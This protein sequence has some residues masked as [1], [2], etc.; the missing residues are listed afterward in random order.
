MFLTSLKQR[1]GCWHRP[2]E[3]SVIGRNS[4][5][6]FGTRT[7]HLSCA[8]LGKAHI[9]DGL[10]NNADEKEVMGRLVEMGGGIDANGPTLSELQALLAAGRI[11]SRE[12]ADVLRAR[13]NRYATDSESPY[14][15][16]AL[17]ALSVVDP[18]VKI[19]YEKEEKKRIGSLAQIES[20][21]IRGCCAGHDS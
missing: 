2:S 10:N 20:G 21:K 3:C 13:V 6:R 4:G 15:I 18:E 12:H 17:K 9:L 11:L 1:S 19:V 7:S 14:R 8:L 16:I 5:R